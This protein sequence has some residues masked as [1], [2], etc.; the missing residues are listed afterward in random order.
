MVRAT[1]RTRPLPVF[2]RQLLVL[3]S[4]DEAQARARI[5]PIGNHQPGAVALHLVLHLPA[6]H[7]KAH[8]A[9][10]PSELVVCQH[11]LDVQILD[12][13]RLVFAAEPGRELV[14]EIRS[15]IG[16]A[17]MEPRQCR[18]GLFAIVGDRQMGPLGKACLGRESGG[19]LGSLDLAVQPPIA[20]F[21]PTQGR[22]ERLGRLDSLAV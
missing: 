18:S 5:P 15:D 17:G 20:D 4:T 10:R 6:D 16:N 9:E 12:H 11:P 2:Q 19:D 22:L 21:E 1:I 13:Y 8:V 7:P 14:D 3:P